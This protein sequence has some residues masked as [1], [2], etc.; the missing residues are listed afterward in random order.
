MIWTEKRNKSIIR[1]IFFDLNFILS[2]YIPKRIAI[3]GIEVERYLVTAGKKYLKTIN[4]K[5]A[6]KAEE[7]IKAKI[8]FF[9]LCLIKR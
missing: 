4:E 2:K 9:F 8:S 1:K 3:P 6:V 5:K 7:K